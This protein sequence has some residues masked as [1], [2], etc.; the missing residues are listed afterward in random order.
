MPWRSLILKQQAP[1][2]TEELAHLQKNEHN[3]GLS[4]LRGFLPPVHYCSQHWWS[5]KKKKR[6]KKLMK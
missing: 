3:W 6:K 1:I 2:P 4:A 5:Y